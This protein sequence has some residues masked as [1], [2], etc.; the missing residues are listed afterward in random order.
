[1]SFKEDII[2]LPR[3]DSNGHVELSAAQSN[4]KEHGK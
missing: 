3:T 4:G 2:G 1:M